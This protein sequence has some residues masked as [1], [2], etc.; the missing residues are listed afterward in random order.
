MEPLR[1]FYADERTVLLMFRKELK[2]TQPAWHALAAVAC[3]LVA[4]I[5]GLTGSLF[6]TNWILSAQDH[7]TLRAIG[8]TLL[9]LALPIA[10]L[11]AHCLD[12]MD[13]SKKDSTLISNFPL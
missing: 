4:V 13:R 7:S 1:P 2:R 3:F 11:G 6:T 10:I 5:A 9:V 8:L 12:L